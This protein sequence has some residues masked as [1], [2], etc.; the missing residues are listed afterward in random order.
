MPSSS[1]SLSASR[2]L[3]IYIYIHTSPPSLFL[4]LSSS[5]LGPRV[6]LRHSSRS[7]FFFS[8]F[9]LFHR[10]L[11]FPPSFIFSVSC[12]SSTGTRALVEHL[13]RLWD[14]VPY[15]PV[16][17]CPSSLF[18]FAPSLPWPKKAK[19]REGDLLKDV[20][21]TGTLIVASVGSGTISRGKLRLVF[22]QDR[23]DEGNYNPVEPT[24]ISP[25]NIATQRD[26]QTLL[27]TRTVLQ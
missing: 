5:Y 24:G 8:F 17:V 27:H 22:A 4:S 23:G 11:S 10:V 19:L 1:L 6:A 9:S 14:S 21:R 15:V 26:T 3:R 25:Q 13:L 16:L 20:L 18:P 2:C 12:S 7:V